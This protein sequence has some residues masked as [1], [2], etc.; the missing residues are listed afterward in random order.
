M[1]VNPNIMSDC[2]EYEGFQALDGLARETVVVSRRLDGHKPLELFFDGVRY[3]FGFSDD[4][5][6]ADIYVN[7]SDTE[8]C[9][10]GC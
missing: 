8:D 5:L 4:I 10:D 9:H 6:G 3:D 2:G 7:T 1:R